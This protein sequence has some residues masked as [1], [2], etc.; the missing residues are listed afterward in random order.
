MA[1]NKKYKKPR[2]DWQI[3]RLDP[4]SSPWYGRK[5]ILEH[6]ERYRF[7]GKQV[8]QKT[9]VELGCGT[10]Y[11]STILA[12]AGAK[13]VI[14]LD[15]SAEAIAYAKKHFADKRIDYVISRAEKTGLEDNFADIVV[16]FETIEHLKEPAQFVAEALRILKPGGSLILS[17]PNRETSFG[18]N[19][20]HLQEFT[21]GE[22]DSLLSAFTTKK[23]FGQRRVTYKLVMFYKKIFRFIPFSGARL[24][25]RFRPWEP[26][27]IRSIRKTS[28]IPY[29]Y[30]LAVC[31]K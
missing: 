13:K 14:A 23:F 26:Y 25:L 19:P 24:L 15:I 3:E 20:Y 12:Q 4:R 9:V 11:G 8:K 18:D 22:L 30:L 17:T 28:T 21:V 1:N 10:G 29:L 6:T 7:A 31:Q 16:S 27:T 2:D 5:L